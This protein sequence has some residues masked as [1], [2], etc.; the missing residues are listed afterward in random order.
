MPKQ[1]IRLLIAFA[2]FIGIFLVTRKIIMPDSFGDI[3]HYRADALTEIASFTPKYTDSL[4]C[5]T[6]HQEIDSLKF[7]GDHSGL[8]CQTC[9]GPGHLHVKNPVVDTLIK[10]ASREFC[11]KCHN[12]NSARPKFIKQVDVTKHNVNSLCVACHNPHKPS[13]RNKSMSSDTSSEDSENVSSVTCDI[14]HG[15]VNSLKSS[16]VHVGLTCQICHANSDK[17][18]EDP[19]ASKPAKPTERSFCGGCHATGN[20]SSGVKQIDIND[21]NS[22]SKCIECHNPHSPYKDF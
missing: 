4:S 18:K 16:G 12:K 20:T 14:C 1:V 10:P 17:H 8:D 15:D 13:M 5:V 7:V 22:G 2:L 9:H 21:H 3:G 6:C 11:A 19:T